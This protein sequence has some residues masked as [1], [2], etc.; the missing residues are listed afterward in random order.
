MNNSDLPILLVDDEQQ[1]LFGY[2]L[3]LRSSGIENI[4]TV[5]DSRKVMP[6]LEKQQVALV[7]LDLI[8]PRISGMELLEKIRLEF[9]RLPVIVMTAINELEKAVECMKA[10]AADYLV[11]PVEESRFLSSIQKV[12]ELEDLQH[13]ITSLKKHLLDGEL[14]NAEAFSPIIT[15]SKK[16]LAIF[17]YIE[18][19]ARSQK[20]V[21]VTGETGSGK[22]LISRIIHLVSG[23][24]GEF[25]AVNAAGLDDTMFSDT[26]FGHRKGAF[27]GADKDRVGLIERASGGTLMLDEI[28]DL[29]KSSQVKLLRLLEEKV[30]YPL[31][32]D[33]PEKSNARIIAC[34]NLDL[35]KLISDGQFRKDLYYRLCGHQIQ[36]PPLRERPHDVPLLLDHFITESSVS[37]KKKKPEPSPEIISLLCNYHFPGNIRE[38]QGM[39]HDAVARHGSGKLSLDSFK[40]LMK[41]RGHISPPRQSAPEE[42]T[43]S[44]GDIFG[45]FPTLKEVEDHLISEAMKCAHGR[46]GSAAALLGITRQA[47]NQRLKKKGGAA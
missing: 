36:I 2:S 7:V 6:L 27:T 44:L 45:H 38:L 18:A 17:H 35:E 32:S 31:G 1:I 29:S 47:L 15:R 46:Q 3:I 42:G 24:K 33:M 37:L 12:L 21:L 13:E 8:M 30:Y 26:L 23:L 5:K 28:G 25:V 39:V 16:M 19:I 40:G 43:V 22:E 11:K 4:I 10:G 9:P 14:E 34:C 20:P 41:K